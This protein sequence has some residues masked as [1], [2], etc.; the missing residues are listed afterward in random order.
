MNVPGPHLEMGGG[1]EF[2]AIRRLL[3]TWTSRAIGIGD[4]GAVLGIPAGE[5]LVASTDSSVEG[6]HF[7]REWLTGREI[8]A[9]AAAAAL[10][11]LAAMGALPRGMLVA[12]CVP[13]GWRGELESI[14]HGLGDVAARVACPIVGGNL[15]SGSELS[16]TLTVLGSALRPLRRSGAQ[17]GDSI[18]VTGR[19]G[20]PGAALRALMMGDAPTDAHRA[21]FAAPM[22]RILE[23]R[24]L[25]DRGARAAIDISDGLKADAAHLARASGVSMVIGGRAVPRVD[26]VS[27]QGAVVSG[28]EYELLVAMPS[29]VAI[30]TAAFASEFGIPLTEI[31]MALAKRDVPVTI[32]D[33][34]DEGEPGFD[35]FV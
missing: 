17:E 5:L 29:G 19:L 4:D 14:A 31:G 35:H 26:G 23:A 9:R 7:R 22:P 20:G 8:G 24:W 34:F 11:D 2:D 15:T 32:T 12:M 3:A 18:F 33:T 21:R 6:V 25:G 16:L 10:S 30:D 13:E 28:E 27:I 1:A